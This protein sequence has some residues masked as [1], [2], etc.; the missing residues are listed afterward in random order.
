MEKLEVLMLKTPKMLKPLT[1]KI[2]KN[3]K[4]VFI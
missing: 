3:L 2:I 1:K 4:P